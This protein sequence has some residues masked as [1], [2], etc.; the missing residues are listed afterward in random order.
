MKG[1]YTQLAYNE[2][3]KREQSTVQ[4]TTNNFKK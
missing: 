4:P 3:K 2:L 1:K